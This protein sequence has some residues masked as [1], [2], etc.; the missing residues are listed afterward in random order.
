MLQRVRRTQA[1]LKER[2]TVSQDTHYVSV[3]GL[4]KTFGAFVAVEGFSVNVREGSTLALLGPSGCGK[5]TA[6]RCIAGLEN[7]DEGV[8]RIGG[9]VVFSAAD[10]VNMQPEER[11]LGIIFQSYAVW[12]H[13]SVAANVGFPLRVRKAPAS[14]IREKVDQ[15]LEMVGLLPWRD[16]PA[17][18]LSGGQQQRVALARALVHQPRLVLFDEPLSNLDAQ[19]RHQMRTE[20]RILQDR[21]KFTAIYVTH[22]Q[23]EAFA[24]AENVVVMN[25]G[26]IEDVAEP[27]EMFKRPKTPFIAKFLGFDVTRGKIGELDESTTRS[28][29]QQLACIDCGNGKRLWGSFRSNAKVAP[30]ALVDVCIRKESVTLTPLR[31]AGETLLGLVRDD[32]TMVVEGTIETSSFLGA[33]DEYVV[34][35]G[36]HRIRVLASQQGLEAGER[37]EV[38]MPVKECIIFPCEEITR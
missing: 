17:T 3:S 6:L 30:G 35:I 19:L 4:R 34:E 27:R 12:P 14:Q 23:S 20:L 2:E 36:Q 25:T 16:R 7:P 38:S 37:V 8:I 21:L 28:T 29:D 13:M 18:E 26:R 32:G 24:L 10:R 33:A 22:D 31:E 11:E 1:S 5:T 15:I 9:Q